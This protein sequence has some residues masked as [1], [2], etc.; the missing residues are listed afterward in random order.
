VGKG[1]IFCEDATQAPFLKMLVELQYRARP[2]AVW[3]TVASTTGEVAAGA[4]EFT[5]KVTHACRTGGWRD[6]ASPWYKAL[7]TD[8]W[9]RLFRPIE[10]QPRKVTLCH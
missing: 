9:S 2:S 1:E 10:S 8:P 3:R 5:L 6:V 7:R 4:V